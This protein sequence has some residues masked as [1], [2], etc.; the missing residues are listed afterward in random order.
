MDCQ[1][2]NQGVLSSNWLIYAWRYVGQPFHE[3]FILLDSCFILC[4]KC[5]LTHCCVGSWMCQALVQKCRS[6]V[7]L[8]HPSIHQ[9]LQAGFPHFFS[10][11][12]VREFLRKFL[13]SGRSHG[14]S[15]FCVFDQERPSLHNCPSRFVMVAFWWII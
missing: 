11:G 7:K 5:A 10:Q 4:H 2:A 1:I 6:D 14:M 12:K 13:K 9:F 3:T 8:S 15:I